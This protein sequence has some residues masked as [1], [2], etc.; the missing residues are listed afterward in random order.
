[1]DKHANSGPGHETTDA[2]AR[3]LA[4]IGISIVVLVG[5]SFLIIALLFK[6]LEYYQPLFDEVPHP[7]A[8]KRQ[9]SSA[10]RIQIDP[11]VQKMELQ[12]NEEHVLTTYDWV[13]QEN[14]LVRIPIIRAIQILSERELPGKTGSAAA[15]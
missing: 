10:P 9:M 8:D 14:N 15:N 3:P 6:V 5:G 7:L 2:P 4:N 1:M 13:D 11:P 12:K